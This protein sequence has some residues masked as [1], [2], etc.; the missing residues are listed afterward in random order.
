MSDMYVQQSIQVWPKAE[1][2]VLWYLFILFVR[3]IWTP[4]EKHITDHLNNTCIGVVHIGIC[5]HLVFIIQVSLLLYGRTPN[6]RILAYCLSTAVFVCRSDLQ[7]NQ[8]CPTSISNE[9]LFKQQAQQKQASFDMALS[10]HYE[11]CTTIVCVYF[12]WIR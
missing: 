9:N 10:L 4:A 1:L 6:T 12:Q 7:S 3:L 2:P 5:M 11:I 8:T